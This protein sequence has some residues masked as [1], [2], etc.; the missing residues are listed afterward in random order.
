M[1]NNAKFGIRLE[2]RALESSATRQRDLQFAKQLWQSCVTGEGMQ[3]DDG[4][5]HMEKCV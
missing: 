4:K 1:L 2:T 5:R 3:I